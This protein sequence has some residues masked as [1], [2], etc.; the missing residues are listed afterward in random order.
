MTAL[1]PPVSAAAIDDCLSAREG[2]L[3]VEGCD[4]VELARRFG[5]PIHVVS[6]NQL[7]RNA[8]RFREAF[9]SRWPEGPVHVLPSIKANLSLALRRILTQEGMGCDTFG[10]GSSR[11]RSG[12]AWSPR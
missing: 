4:A 7:R 5:T 10:R 6:E 3:F 12:A 9:G 11:P 8:R 2:H 1:E